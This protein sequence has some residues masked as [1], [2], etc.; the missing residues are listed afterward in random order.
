MIVIRHLAIR[1]AYPVESLADL[2][3]RFEPDESI[4]VGA[5]D[6]FAPVSV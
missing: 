6:V 1:M 4:I 3:K 5:E 2:R